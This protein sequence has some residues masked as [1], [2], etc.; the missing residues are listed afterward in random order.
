MPRKRISLRFIKP[1]RKYDLEEKIANLCKKAKKMSISRDVKICLIVV[2][3]RE[4][5]VAAWP[6]LTEASDIVRDH[7]EKQLM[8]ILRMKLV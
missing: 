5:D 3:P 7:L 1:T 4:T 8:K 6:S 2:I